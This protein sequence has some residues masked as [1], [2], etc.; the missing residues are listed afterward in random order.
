LKFAIAVAY[1]DPAHLNPIARTAEASGFGCI[2]VSDHVIYPGKLETPYPYT[3]TGKP[4]WEPETPWPDPF[5]A[6]ASMA[7]VTERIEFITSI[8]VLTLRHPVLAAKTIA[9][10]SLLSGGRL[11]LGVGA[12]WMREEFDLLGQRFDRRGQ[13][14]SESIEVMRKLWRGG[15]V[16]HHGQ[17]YDF[18]PVQMSPAPDRPI[19]IYG[20]GLSKPALRRAAQLCDG[21]ASEIQTREELIG[22]N[23]ELRHMRAES[24]RADEPFGLCVALKDVHDLDGYREMAD[25]G[26]SELITVPWLFYGGQDQSCEEKCAGIRRFGDEVISKLSG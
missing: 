6:V 14:L 3:S 11:K 8:F 25:L 5:V 26:V 4:R 17:F 1:N 23:K 18:D 15:M 10:T 16:E 19:P 20:G 12:G 9:T 24:E 13:R 2:V 21:W 7:A 22:I